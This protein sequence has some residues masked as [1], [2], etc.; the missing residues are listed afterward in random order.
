MQIKLRRE[1]DTFRLT[2]VKKSHIIYVFL[3]RRRFLPMLIRF[4]VENFL[5]Y[6]ERNVFSM[7][8]GRI[9]RHARH[10]CECN[11]E[12]ILRSAFVFGANAGGKSSFVKALDF[13][14]RVVMDGV[15]PTGMDKLHFRLGESVNPIGAFQYDIFTNGKFYS[16]SFA[17]DY[18]NASVVDES[19]Y[20]IVDEEKEVC[21]FHRQ[22]TNEGQVQI[23]TDLKLADQDKNRFEIYAEDF[24]GKAMRK[25]MFLRDIAK[26][27]SDQTD[28]GRDAASVM[29]WFAKMLVIFPETRFVGLPSY[30]VNKREKDAVAGLMSHF[31]TGIDDL[32]EEEMDVD[33]FWEQVPVDL[34][35]R[36]KSDI[37]RDLSKGNGKAVVTVNNG[38]STFV[39]SYSN[40]KI[41]VKK[42]K[43]DHGN[44]KDLFERSEESDG[45]I[46]LFDLVPLYENWRNGGVVVI[47]EI[48][49]S[50]HTKATQEFVRLF[51]EDSKAQGSQ[52]IATTHDGSL[53]DLDILRQ[54]EIWFAERGEDKSTTLYSL[55]KFKARFDKDIRKDYFLG[56]YGA[57]PLFDIMESSEQE[58]KCE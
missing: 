6:K 51:L 44:K 27:A 18:R 10:I 7:A 52:L 1:I 46:R 14:R 13:G 4:V 11:G 35:D 38:F 28:F 15:P 8:A 39:F 34:K 22:K 33:K 20:Q 36:L 37:L 40:G 23:E 2:F 56:R 45:T 32:V 30:M 16:Y 42:T 50:L 43:E 3:G 29:R 9:T 41:V 25:E 55:S 53:L 31:D 49:R 47:D 12:K 26:R 21:I 54:D 48:D 19:L 58:G 17:L 24:R 5:S 57:L